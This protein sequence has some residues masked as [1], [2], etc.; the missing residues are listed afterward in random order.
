M[1][2]TNSSKKSFDSPGNLMLKTHEL[3]KIDDRSVADISI[4]TGISFFWLQRFSAH[5]MK[6]PSVNRVEY[7]YE[8]LSGKK[9]NLI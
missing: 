8:H 7:L 6:N 5:M 3:L 1:V 4:A 2:K 9:L